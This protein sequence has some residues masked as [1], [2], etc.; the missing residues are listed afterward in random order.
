VES[1]GSLPQ[2]SEKLACTVNKLRLL[3]LL[4]THLQVLLSLP[5]QLLL[6]YC[7]Q[8]GSTI[9]AQAAGVPTLP[10]SGSHVKVSFEECAGNIPADVY[11]QACIHN[12]DDALSCCQSIGY[13]CMLKASWGGGGKGIRKVG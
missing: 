9:L 6:T 7:A 5:V 12:M 3:G 8:V 11:D 2:P 10:W 1:G 13:P 4:D